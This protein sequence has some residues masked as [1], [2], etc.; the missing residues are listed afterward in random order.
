MKDKY[1][2]KF[3]SPRT[4]P[5]FQLTDGQKF[6]PICILSVYVGELEKYLQMLLKEWTNPIYLMK[7]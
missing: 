7:Y 1:F 6:L 5:G 3:G 2:G 4:Q